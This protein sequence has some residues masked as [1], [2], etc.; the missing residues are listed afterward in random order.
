MNARFSKCVVSVVLIAALALPALA[1]APFAGA[2][3]DDWL[4]APTGSY[5]VGTTYYHWVDETRDEVFTDDPDDKRELVV[6][7]WYPA[8][9]EAGTPSATYFPYGEVE[10]SGFEASQGDFAALVSPEAVALTPT[11]SYLDVPVSAAQP[12]YPLLIYSPGWPGTE[13]IGTALQQELASHGYI[14]AAI[15]YPYVSGWTVFPDGHMVVSSISDA[16][17]D[18][19]LEVGAQD[20][21]FVLDRL[22]ELNAS[23]AGEQFGGRLELDRIGTMGTS[24]GAWVTGLGCA[25]DDRFAAALFLG[26]HGTLPKA[27]IDAGLDVPTMILDPGGEATT[28]GGFNSMDGPAYRLDLNGVSGLNMADF[29]LWPGLAEGLPAEVIGQVEP[30][31][32]VQIVSAYAL[33]FFDRYIRDEEAPLLDGPSPDFPEVKITARNVQ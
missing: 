11:D 27:V 10:V 15:N 25:L 26:P 28:H 19:S 12:S 14:I 9:V 3:E 23:P 16:M 20:Q 18:L 7:F 24:W 8:D 21:A 2:Q 1:I 31:R 17:L 22:E 33:A 5:Q 29:L 32:G 4:P 13:S 6:R 30:T